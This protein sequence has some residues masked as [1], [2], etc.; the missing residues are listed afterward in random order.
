MMLN[1]LSPRM[2]DS[3]SFDAYLRRTYG[4]P[5]WRGNPQPLVEGYIEVTTGRFFL[6][7]DNGGWEKAEADAYE[8]AITEA[9]RLKTKKV[10][11]PIRVREIA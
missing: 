6:K 4:L 11:K 3:R 5:D 9:A 7:T 8:L 10:N 2:K 1:Y